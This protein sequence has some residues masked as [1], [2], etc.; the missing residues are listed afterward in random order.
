MP[1]GRDVRAVGVEIGY[2]E[3]LARLVIAGADDVV[4]TPE[5]GTALRDAIPSA[6]LVVIPGAKHLLNVECPDE[7]AGLVQA[8]LEMRTP[9]EAGG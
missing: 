1:R 7:V 8:F 3:A 9:A 5:M 4:T 2:D 6:E